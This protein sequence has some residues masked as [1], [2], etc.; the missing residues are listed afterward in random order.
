[1][2]YGEAS[3]SPS[4]GH[5][6]GTVKPKMFNPVLAVEQIQR[7]LSVGLRIARAV[8][9]LAPQSFPSMIHC[10]YRDGLLLWRQLRQHQLCH[11]AKDAHKIAGRHEKPRL[12]AKWARSYHDPE[13]VQSVVFYG[14]ALPQRL[15]ATCALVTPLYTCLGAQSNRGTCVVVPSGRRSW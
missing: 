8:G 15:C 3:G 5:A 10:T 11:C 1:M 7:S 9:A 2:C 12:I 13:P 14:S 4:M 6:I